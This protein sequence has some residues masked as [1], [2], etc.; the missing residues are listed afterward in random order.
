[1]KMT[2]KRAKELRAILV[3]GSQ[4]LTDA[5]ASKAPELF[6][7]MIYD[8]SRIKAG[9]RI[10]WQGEVM[11]AG[12][13]LWAREDQN[14]ANAPTLWE[15]LPFREGIRIIPET[16]TVTGAFDQGEKGWWKDVL[17]E[18]KKAANVYNPDIRPQDWQV[19]KA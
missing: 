1:M 19:V 15:K 12:S 5:D 14:P 13:D 4:S 17:Y 3:K 8:G 18:S 2:R 16:I 9:T 7:G 11:K 6:D 10:N